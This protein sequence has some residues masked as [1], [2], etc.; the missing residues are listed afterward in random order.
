VSLPEVTS[1]GEGA[2]CDTGGTSLSVTLGAESPG[3]GNFMF[4]DVEVP[5]SVTVKLPSDADEYY[6]AAPTDAEDQ[7][8]SNAFRGMGWNRETGEYG[9]G[10]VND[11][12]AL[13]FAALP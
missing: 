5:K 7:N 12:I 13:N 4:Y 9:T 2:F 8:W 6:G 11:K 3:L 1:I 10:E